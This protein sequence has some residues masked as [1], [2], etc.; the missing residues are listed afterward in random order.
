MSTSQKR[1]R[2]GQNSVVG[3]TRTGV[4]DTIVRSPVRTY[5][6][7]AREEATAPDVIAGIFYLFDVTMYVLIDLGSNYSYI[8]TELVTKKK[9]PVES[10]NYD[11]QVTNPLGQSVIVNLVFHKCLLK[12]KGCE[13]PAD[14]EFDVI[15]GLDWLSLYDAVKQIDLKCQTRGVV[16][17]EY[18]SPKDVVRI[19]L[20]FYAQRLICKGSEAFLAY[21]LDT[22]DSELRL[23]QLLVVS[24]FIDVFPEELLGLPPDCEVEFVIDLVPRTA[25]ILISPYHMA[26]AELKELKAQLQDLLDRGKKKDDSLRLCIDYRCHSVLEDRSQIRVKDCNV[27]KTT[28]RTRYVPSGLTNTPVAFMDL[29]NQGF[30]P[31][32]DRFVVVFIDDILIYSKIKF[33]HAQH[34]R[35]LCTKFSKCEF[36]LREVGFLGHIVSANGLQVDP[37]KVP[38]MIN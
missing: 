20:A 15:L 31:Y 38:A 32:L 11:I 21:I 36:W 33:E 24:K 25:P 29:M 10:T 5:A 35:I 2:P 30:Q 16:S 14:W 19:I 1:R 34:L 27:S 6:I 26:S 12:V 17:V 9:L 13:F 37:S 8:Y 22:R 18:E 7:R 4:K 28:F 23:D 3:T